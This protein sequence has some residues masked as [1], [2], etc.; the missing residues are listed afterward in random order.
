MLELQ[1]NVHRKGSTPALC[2][3]PAGGEG[4][5]KPQRRKYMEYS[6][7]PKNSMGLDLNTG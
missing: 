7:D 1:V 4:V 5:T 6:R 2:T 3:E